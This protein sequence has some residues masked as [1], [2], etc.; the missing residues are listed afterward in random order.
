MTKPRQPSSGYYATARIERTVYLGAWTLA[1]GATPDGRWVLH[2]RSRA[3]PTYQ[4][5]YFDTREQAAAE[6]DAWVARYNAA[7]EAGR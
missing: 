6:L 2:A 7:G 5:A 4:R 3:A 1:L